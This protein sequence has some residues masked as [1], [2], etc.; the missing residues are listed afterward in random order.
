M[1]AVIA[2]SAWAMLLLVSNREEVAQPPL[3][4]T[5]QERSAVEETR[6]AAQSSRQ[7]SSSHQKRH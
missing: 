1:T 4:V 6:P 3:T 7:A 2:L 5:G